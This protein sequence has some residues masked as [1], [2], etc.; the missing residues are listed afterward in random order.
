MKLPA[1][2]RRAAALLLTALLLAALSVPAFADGAGIDLD[3]DGSISMRCQ[4]QGKPVSGGDMRL[5]L[6]GTVEQDDGNY[7]F[8]LL[9]ALG[10]D[11][12][13][14]KALDSGDLADRLSADP[15]L[16][17]LP[18]QRQVFDANGELCFSTNVK[19]GLYLLL[20]STAA[21][22][23]E[24]MKPVVV[25]VPFIDPKTGEYRYDVDATVKPAL[26]RDVTTPPPTPTPAPGSNLPQTGQLN[27]P[28][29]VMA[30]LGLLC[31]LSGL[32]LLAGDRRRQQ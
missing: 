13:D 16:Q 4:Y 30:V 12:L 24:K 18:Y 8:Q 14:Q 9:D 7:F 15:A 27:W 25:S 19:P 11:K 10:G 17:D 26:E 1:F 3:R 32:A 5:Y 29:P 23:F 20:Q 21:P 22:G 2:S 31:V 28:V 6:V